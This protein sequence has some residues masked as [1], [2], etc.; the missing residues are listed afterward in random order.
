MILLVLLFNI[1]G[2]SVFSQSPIIG[3]KSVDIIRGWRQSDDIHIAAINIKLEDGWKTYWR[4]PG[5]GGI[6]PILNW[7][8]SKN[9]KN[10]SQIWPTPNIYNEYGLQ[11]IGYKDELL[12]PL[13]IQPIDKKQ[14]IHLS[15]TI[16]F[17][18]CSDVCVPI[19]TTVEKRLPERTSI[20]KKNILDTLEKAILSGK[21]S[22]FKIVK[23]NIVPIKDGFEVNAFFE[24]LAS[25]DKDTLGV[26]EYPVKQ[27]GWINQKASLVSGNQLNVHATVYN[28]SIHFIDR[29]DLT[30][31]IFTKNK[32]FEFDGCIS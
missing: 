24:G 23:C 28:K 2:S 11:T 3:L 17:G 16:D 9:I 7:D 27:N 14:P 19:Q 5:I 15:V 26:V 25:F 29:S 13:Q 22:P 4:V 21:K 30:L 1:A 18:I 20:G 12:L 31:T 8:K 10:I 6:A 32:A